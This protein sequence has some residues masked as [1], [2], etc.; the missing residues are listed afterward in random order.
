MTI[1]SNRKSILRGMF[2][3]T[4]VPVLSDVRQG[5]HGRTDS[6]QTRQE[7]NG[8]ITAA[9]DTPGDGSVKARNM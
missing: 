4:I 5:H 9:Q 8:S 2:Q 3:L 6:Q 1:T 7:P